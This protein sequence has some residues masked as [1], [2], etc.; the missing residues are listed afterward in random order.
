MANEEV[1]T[2]IEH[3]VDRSERAM[4]QLT[5]STRGKIEERRWKGEDLRR[6]VRVNT[7][8][9][10]YDAEDDGKLPPAERDDRGQRRGY[11]LAQALEAMKLFKTLPWRKDGDDPVIL[12]F[13]NFKGGCWKTTSAHYFV[14]WAAS[15]GYRVLA[16]DLDP[17]GS[18]TRNLGV[19]PDME[20]SFDETLAPLLTRRELPTR[21]ALQKIIRTTHIPTLEFIPAS[22]DLQVVEWSLSRDAIESTQTGNAPGQLG[23]FLRLKTII[24]EIIGD[25][26]LIVIDGTPTLG[27][28]PLNIILASDGVVVPVPTEIADYCSTVSFLRI[29]YDHLADL[30]ERYADQI[31]FPNMLFLPTRFTP[32]A[33]TTMGAEHVL[34]MIKSSFGD[35]AIGSVIRK[36]DSVISNLSLLCRTAF[37][38]NTGEGGVKSD[39]RKRATANYSQAFD[40]IMRKLVYPHWPNKQKELE[41]LEVIHG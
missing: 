37:D 2:H 34:A 26:D 39:S 3:W 41:L 9:R 28:I 12:S 40:E 17:Q 13:T 19:M 4:E 32:G 11:T 18:L 27:L 6:L 15:L 24:D 38:T 29:L 23:A 14:T 25:Y 31:A 33:Q 21:E 1:L 5:R 30:Y 20:T 10:I 16:I 8:Q 35:G 22:L 36:H 7:I